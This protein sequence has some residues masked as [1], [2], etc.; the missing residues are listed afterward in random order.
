MDFALR[1]IKTS[2][3]YEVIFVDDGSRDNS[4][5]IIRELSQK[6][7]QARGIKFRRNY[8]K[9]AALHEGFKRLKGD[10]VN[11]AGCRHAGQPRR[12]S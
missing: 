11:Y 3:S 6:H 9:S 10:V 8:G 12:N 1:L 4:W 2:F 5:K 7:P